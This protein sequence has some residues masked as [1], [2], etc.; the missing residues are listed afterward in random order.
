MGPGVHFVAAGSRRGWWSTVTASSVGR[1]MRRVVLRRLRDAAG[2]L[3][4]AVAG[5]DH[6][7]DMRPGS[8]SSVE[9]RAQNAPAHRG[10]ADVHDRRRRCRQLSRLGRV[11][12]ELQTATS[13][14]SAFAPCGV[15]R[16]P[17]GIGGVGGYAGQRLIGPVSD[18][19]RWRAGANVERSPTMA[20]SSG[21]GKVAGQHERDGRG[22]DQGRRGVHAQRA[23]QRPPGVDGGH[24][25]Q[26]A[27]NDER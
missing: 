15:A 20:A 5:D 23:D 27:D 2:A 10:R 4:R 1:R 8:G 3:G 26:R 11:F 17:A 25:P 12:T 21:Q 18:A 19:S 22:H 24:C 6:A 9:A 16:G 13:W 14:C 7:H